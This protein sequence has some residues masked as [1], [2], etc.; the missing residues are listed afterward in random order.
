MRIL[1]DPISAHHKVIFKKV[2]KAIKQRK[3]SI[4]LTTINKT[5]ELQVDYKWLTPDLIT[6]N[7]A[8]TGE[9]KIRLCLEH[10]QPELF[11]EEA[12]NP[13]H[14]REVF[15]E[16]II[17]RPLLV[18]A[19]GGHIGQAL[20]IQAD[21]VGFD[22]MVLDDRSEFTNPEL[23]P[24][25]ATTLC[26]DIVQELTKKPA[27][28]D[29]YIVIVTR[30]HKNDAQALEV[31]ID[32]PFNYIGMIGSKRKVALIREN[33]IQSGISTAEQ[34]DKIFSPIGLNIGAV[35]VPEIAASIIAE[36]IAVRRMGIIHKSWI[37]MEIL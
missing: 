2:A 21:L 12:Q 24:E 16:P 33:F 25:N 13:N 3:K 22:I 32:K 23:F 18:I 28:K 37:D 4:L 17:P 8:F 14:L 5:Q 30:G 26:C 35:T 7:V 10:E 9:E 19:G 1:I 6:L 20:A 34:F 31:C 11:I 15:V 36:L 27:E 29:M